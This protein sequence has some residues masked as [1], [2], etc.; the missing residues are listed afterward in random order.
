MRD[1]YLAERGMFN[2]D[3]DPV[4]SSSASAD[5][6]DGLEIKDAAAAATSRIGTISANHYKLI[7]LTCLAST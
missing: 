6:W 1:L 5:A 4:T 2:S 7:S 3:V